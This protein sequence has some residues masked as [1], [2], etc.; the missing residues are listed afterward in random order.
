MVRTPTLRFDRGTLILHPPPR[1]KGWIEHAVW[2]DRIE[3]F[4][5]PA[6]C[7]R[8]LLESL[9]QDN[10]AIE[11]HASEFKPLELQPNLTYDPYPHQSEALVAWQ[12]NRWQGVVVLPTAA[13]KTYLAQLAMQAIPRSVL[14][15]VPTLDL[16][17][18]WYAHLETAFPNADIGLLG[19]GSRDRTDILVATYDSAA[20]HA[21]NLG[22]RYGLLVCDECHHLPSD[23]N[24]VIAEY[25]IAPYRLGLTAT[26]DRADGRHGDLDQLLG[27]VVY[28]KT[29][30]ELSGHALAPY[31]IIQLKV[32]LSDIERRRYSD[33]IQQRNDFLQEAKIWLSSPEGW[34]RFVAAS[35]RSQS[36]RRAML[37]HREAKT[38]AL[39]TAGKLRILEDLLAQHYPERTIIFT[40]D[41]ATVY[42]ISQDFLI[43]AITHQ[44]PVKER[45][46]ILQNFRNGDY[47]A[48]VVSHVLNEGVD[49]PEARVAVLLSGSGSTREY[50]QRLGRVLRKGDGNKLALLYEVIAEETTE[51]N[52]ARRR[53]KSPRQRDQNAYRPKP[54][55]LPLVAEADGTPEDLPY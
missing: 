48:V 41:N 30:A 6:H 11:D 32:S 24:R 26:P 21:E 53:K 16:M 22:N 55:K 3:R 8:P 1:G 15:T 20:I 34:K 40:N 23:F 37:A 43:P 29:A 25:A 14:I 36:G 27:P 12:Q 31:Q 54:L 9:R 2:D 49:V 39:G 44:T 47:T 18:Q 28:S 35:A 10:V 45:R 52:I 33:L 51:E 19:G 42:K 4:R 50:I 17:H 5:I 46:Q 13:G 7:Y 38:I